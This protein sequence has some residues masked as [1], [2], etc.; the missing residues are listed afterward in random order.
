MVSSDLRVL[1]EGVPYGSPI[2]RSGNGVPDARPSPS[3]RSTEM[4]PFP[5]LCRPSTR[6]LIAGLLALGLLAGCGGDDDG[7]DGS[8]PTG[9]STAAAEP[10]VVRVDGRT[11]DMAGIGTAEPLLADGIRAFGP[12]SS[13]REVDG[14]ACHVRWASVGL[15]AIY[16]NLGGE[17][18][19]DPQHG[20]LQGGALTG[21]RWE[22][23]EGLAIGDPEARLHELY[24]AAA[25]DENR[26]T[27]ASAA[28]PGGRTGVLSAVVQEG[29]IRSIQTYV[30]AAG[31]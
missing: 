28:G 14:T 18:P 9:T 3:L 31:D 10:L 25:A 19:C 7:D 26:W 13:E 8:Q 5:R 12:P 27:L 24:P 22:T 16:A 4:R 21:E 6:G 1:S 17:D 20:R 29:E 2:A 23:S 30:G 11:V 15:F